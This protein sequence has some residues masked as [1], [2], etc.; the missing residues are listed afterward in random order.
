MATAI[1]QNYSFESEIEITIGSFGLIH[2]NDHIDV[3]D[4][5]DG[6]WDL[7]IEGQPSGY[8]I[9]DYRLNQLAGKILVK[10]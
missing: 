1:L 7:T 3:A 2:E 5:G 6:T 9:D 8:I 10:M 4:R